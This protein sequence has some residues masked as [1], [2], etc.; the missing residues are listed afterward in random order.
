MHFIR[1]R[2][3]ICLSYTAKAYRW[4][5]NKAPRILNLCIYGDNLTHLHSGR[6][7]PEKW[8]QYPLQRKLGGSKKVLDLVA[9]IKIRYIYEDVLKVMPPNCLLPYRDEIFIFLNSI[10][11]FYAVL[12]MISCAVHAVPPSSNSFVSQSRQNCA[13][14]WQNHIFTAVLT[15]S[16]AKKWCP[17]RCFFSVRKRWK[18]E[19]SLGCMVESGLYGGVWVVWW[20]GKDGEPKAEAANPSVVLVLVW[21]PRIFV[22]DENQLHVRTK[23]SNMCLQLSLAAECQQVR[24]SSVKK[25]TQS[26]HT[27][28]LHWLRFLTLRR[29]HGCNSKTSSGRTMKVH[30]ELL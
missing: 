10:L 14:C 12:N 9:K 30:I 27:G 15:S 17:L 5:V 21:G 4:R 8:P 11:K 20:M 29:F 19:P 6:L 7:A 28:F 24:F 23:F 26:L 1:V 13:S 25:Q 16:S 18:S 2:L 22:L 3:Y